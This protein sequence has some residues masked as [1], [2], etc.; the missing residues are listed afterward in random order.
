MSQPAQSPFASAPLLSATRLL[1]LLLC[2]SAAG[3]WSWHNVA[4]LLQSAQMPSF[5]ALPLKYQ[6]D[7][8]ML[9]LLVSFI[10]GSLVFFLLGYL[11]PALVGGLRLFLVAWDLRRAVRAGWPGN[12]GS[13]PVERSWWYDP[14]FTRLWHEFAASLQC[15][16]QPGHW[17]GEERLVYRSTV[18]SENCFNTVLLV[19]IPMRVEFFRHLP[20]LLTGAGIVS[21]FIGIL[22]G[23]SQFN[24]TTEP[25]QIAIQL[26][27]LFT[28][29]ATAFVASFL[30]IVTAMAVTLTEKWL[31]HWRYA[32]IGFLH[33]FIDFLFPP[34]TDSE[35]T[36]ALTRQNAHS[37]AMVQELNRLTTVL[38]QQWGHSVE[39]M[40]SRFHEG[41]RDALLEPLRII[42]QSIRLVVTQRQEEQPSLAAL[43]VTVER[44]YEWLLQQQS[45][46]QRQFELL[47]QLVV[48]SLAQHVS[49]PPAEPPADQSAVVM[50]ELMQQL[51]QWPQRLEQS[52][53][54]ARLLTQTEQ[55]TL[56]LQQQGHEVRSL[57]E[58]V[59]QQGI[60]I[61]RLLEQLHE[62]SH[63]IH[64]AA[65]ESTVAMQALP[66]QIRPES[67]RL[68]HQMTTITERVDTVAAV[69]QGLRGELIRQVD[70]FLIQQERVESFGPQLVDVV[71]SALAAHQRQLEQRLGDMMQTL[72]QQQDLLWQNSTVLWQSLGLPPAEQMVQGVQSAVND[73]SGD[74]RQQLQQVMDTL[75]L[76]LNSHL[77]HASGHLSDHLAAMRDQLV[78]EQ[79]TLHSDLRQWVQ[80]LAGSNQQ[81][82]QSV[83]QRMAD[84]LTWSKGRHHDLLAALDQFNQRIN[85]DLV[86][87]MQH[88]ESEILQRRAE[89]DQ[90]MAGRIEQIVRHN[91]GEQAAFI[92]ML[93]ERLDTLRQRLKVR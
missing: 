43:T 49:E 16:R 75:L 72:Q 48:Q 10:S 28:G 71:S 82:M 5:L 37:E 90:V 76:S 81:E 53:G 61:A 93:S 8:P 55:Q 62:T 27:Q 59:S 15:H 60:L 56:L 9:L 25:G 36:A 67:E 68:L 20:G 89:A 66:D 21:T 6:P 35:P 13:G 63:G 77:E 12:P 32:Q 33:R 51:S 50:A 57:S 84:F 79:E 86:D 87:K 46:S 74:V 70:R 58:Q 19:D 38:Q 26:E 7:A 23:L 31:L 34:V 91:S 41:I 42:S 3:W 64:A 14:L 4:A 44:I 30:A 52:D 78:G 54:L 45:D 88:V 29:V 1:L 24:P 22:F 11:L 73:I 69:T 40:G 39:A 80:Q 47:Q 85:A 18:A 83:H 65:R 92:E 17:P 2:A